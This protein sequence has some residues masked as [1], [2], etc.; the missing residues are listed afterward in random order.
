MWIHVQKRRLKR[1]NLIV[2]DA[3]G[4]GCVAGFDNSCQILLT[5]QLIQNLT[6]WLCEGSKIPNSLILVLSQDVIY[7]M[8]LGLDI[9]WVSCPL[10]LTSMT[11]SSLYLFSWCCFLF[12]PSSSCSL[13]LQ[14]DSH[15]WRNYVSSSIS[16]VDTS[17]MTLFA[18]LTLKRLTWLMVSCRCRC[19]CCHL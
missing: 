18:V 15:H 11:P 10:G 9:P 7:R 6:I 5:E 14:W 17:I 8:F 19:A 16:R 3:F 2:G 1:P 4:P 13:W 12:N